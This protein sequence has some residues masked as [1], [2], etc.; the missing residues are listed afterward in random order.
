MNCLLPAASIHLIELRGV[1]EDNE[2]YL[3]VLRDGAVAFMARCVD[4][5]LYICLSSHCA[6][7][8]GI[9]TTNVAGGATEPLTVTGN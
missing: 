9:V 5:F 2:R 8:A 7:P 1:R 4:N 6:L 3:Y